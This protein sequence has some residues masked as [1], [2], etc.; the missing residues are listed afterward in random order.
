MV[1]HVLEVS[2]SMRPKALTLGNYRHTVTVVRSLARAG[3]DVIVGRE[4]AERTF[5]QFSRYVSGEVWDHPKPE[6][7]PEDF[8]AT[9]TEFIDRRHDLAV[10]FPIGETSL[11]RIAQNISRLPA[12]ARFIM[13]EPG[14]L[15]ACL[16]K[17][18]IYKTVTDLGIPLPASARVRNL[19]EMIAEARRIGYPVIVKPNRSFNFFFNQKAIICRTPDEIQKTFWS[20]PPDNDFLIMQQY[21]EGYRPNC[22]FAARDGQIVSYFEHN[23]IRTDRLD[24]T[25][26]EVDGVSVKPTPRLRDY[27]EKLTR[28]LRYS[29]VGCVQ[30]LADSKTTRFYFLEINPR[31]DATCA[32][33]YHCGFDFPRMA[34]DI[35]DYSGRPVPVLSNGFTDIYPAGRRAYWLLGDVLGLVHSLEDGSVNRKTALSWLKN[36]AGSTLAADLHLTFSWK[37][38]APT[39]FLYAKL[40]SSLWGRIKKKLLYAPAD[41][42]SGTGL[43]PD[44][45]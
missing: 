32:L 20:W 18:A 26:F 8:I 15:L 25:G 39:G 7:E 27:C 38:P 44:K 13:P 42:S 3:Y 19:K 30:F 4:A 33:P 24:E 31:L 28:Y 14:A 29:G 43:A 34:V 5:T 12:R 16:D 36:M 10:V 22:H 41:N 1:C 2:R 9:L 11:Q 35:M 21:I 37:D 23:V 45:R 6:Q 40:V 17:A